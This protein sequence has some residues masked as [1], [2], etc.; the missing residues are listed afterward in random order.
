MRSF[1]PNNN[2]GLHYFYDKVMTVPILVS[3]M[4][5]WLSTSINSHN[6]RLPI[7]FIFACNRKDCLL[8]FGNKD[9]LVVMKSL[10]LFLITHLQFL[11]FL[12]GPKSWS[13]YIFCWG[14]RA[15]VT[16]ISYLHSVGNPSK[17]IRSIYILPT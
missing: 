11:F 17:S 16:H 9:G 6:I 7:P 14:H 8:S 15:N 13:P 10:S 5:L 2:H 4:I 3:L 1:I 12:L